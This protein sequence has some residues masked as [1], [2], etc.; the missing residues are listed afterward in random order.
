MIGHF[1]PLSCAFVLAGLAA[2]GADGA[3]LD[4]K[5]V[6]DPTAAGTVTF[7]FKLDGNVLTGT[8]TAGPLGPANIAN[9]KVEG[10]QISFQ[11]TR[12]VLLSTITTKYSGKVSRDV[13]NLHASNSRGEMDLVVRKQ[14]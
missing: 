13:M 6:T 12:K 8:A 4:G 5:W 3:K 10:D 14:P 7:V 11:V 2:F 9:G 1:G